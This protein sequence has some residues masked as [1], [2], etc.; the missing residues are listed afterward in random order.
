MVRHD[1]DHFIGLFCRKTFFK[2]NFVLYKLYLNFNQFFISQLPGFNEQ[3]ANIPDNTTW[4]W[5]FDI[6]HQ[7][8]YSGMPVDEVG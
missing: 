8:W 2:V 7:L 5:R 3:E 6:S 4:R 1:Y